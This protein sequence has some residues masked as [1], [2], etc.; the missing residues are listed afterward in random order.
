MTTM[1]SLVADTLG[2]PSEV[3]HL[4]ARPIP[5]PGPGEVRIRVVA[6]PVHASD[7]HTIR[8]RY[9]FTPEF[10]AVPG[11]ESVGVIDELGSGTGGLSIGQRV[12]TIGVTG[13]W[14]EY[15]VAEAARVLPVPAGMSDSTAAQILTNPLTAVILTGAELD[16]RP[17]EWLVQTAA[18]STVGQLVIQLGAH[19]GFKTLNVVR[20]RSAVEEI[21]ALGGTAV[22][23]TADEDLRERVADIAGHNGVSK[24]IDCVGGQVGADVSR[25][26]APHGELVVYG[27]LSTHRQTDPDKLVVPVFARSLIYETKTVRGFWLFRWITETPKDRIAAAI[28]RTLQLADSGALRVPEGQPIPLEMFSDA[29][30]SAEA[31]EHGG[32]P[33]LV[34]EQ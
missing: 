34:F 31:P 18:G 9:G 23:C 8:G 33:L 21:L 10:P 22:I 17:G 7:L 14:Q 3:L 28:D 24:A 11:I 32:K 12:V 20:R 16:V 13:T 2:E 27:A 26:L 1:R 29:V 6:V 19:V 30:Y 4:R 25:A 15:I 5:E